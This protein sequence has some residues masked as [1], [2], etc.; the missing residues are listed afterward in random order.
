MRKLGSR[1][2]IPADGIEGVIDRTSIRTGRTLYRL[3][4]PDG[5]HWYDAEEVRAA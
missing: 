3:A 4:S 2:R 1:V 5:G